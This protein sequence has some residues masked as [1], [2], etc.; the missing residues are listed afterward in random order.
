MN[1]FAFI[2]NS[3]LLGFILGYLLFLIISAMSSGKMVKGEL[4][5]S[6]PPTEPSRIL[7]ARN[8]LSREQWRNLEASRDNIPRFLFRG[9]SARSSGGD[10][11]LNSKDG[12]V[13]HY[14]LDGTQPTSMY[15]VRRLALGEFVTHHLYGTPVSTPFSSWTQSITVAMNFAGS[16]HSAH[17][18]IL[19]TTLLAPH[20][21]IYHTPSL[22]SAGLTGA[23]YKEE[24]L[25]YGPINGPAFHYVPCEDFVG[26]SLM[27]SPYP[28]VPKDI[29]DRV[30]RA[31]KTARLFRPSSDKRP[32]IVI[33]MTTY[34]SCLLF[35]YLAN[36]HNPNL[37]K[38]LTVHLEKEMKAVKLPPATSDVVGLVNPKMDTSPGGELE[39][40][41]LLLQEIEKKV[42][43]LGGRGK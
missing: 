33:V 26:T 6:Q 20:V 35:G 19:D 2:V 38:S 17:I 36:I 10:P 1:A 22:K 16:D 9:F 31:K 29:E 39:H 40:M 4:K 12:I 27:R 25:A 11:R 32:D 43:S 23:S 15:H 13:P 41:V 42:R 34:L 14:S 18:A 21:S 30:I 8:G 3:I 7:L 28:I 37:L 5:S 24:Y